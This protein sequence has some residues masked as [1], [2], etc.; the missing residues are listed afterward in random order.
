MEWVK[1][2]RVLNL[3][4]LKKSWKALM[5]QQLSNIYQRISAE[6]GL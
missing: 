3:D 6:I 1:K 5:S 4:V 2:Y